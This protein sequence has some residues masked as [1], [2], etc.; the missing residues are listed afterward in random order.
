MTT[1][2]TITPTARAHR[3]GALPQVADRWNH[4]LANNHL[5][6][7]EFAVGRDI[8]CGAAKMIRAH[9][10]T[11]S[12]SSDA[13][14]NMLTG[15][16]AEPN[17]TPIQIPD[18]TPEAFTN[19]LSYIYTGSVKDLNEDNVQPT[20]YCADKYELPW[21]ADLCTEFVLDLLKPE[22]C[23]MHLE[24]ALHWTK[25]CDVVIE[26]CWDIVD[27]SSEAVLQSDYFSEMEWT[28]LDMLLQRNT[29]SAEENTVYLAAEKWARAACAR[30]NLPADAAHRRRILGSALYRVRF[31]LMTD[32]QLATGPFKDK[33]K[34]LTKT[35]LDTL[36]Q[37]K[38]AASNNLQKF[39]KEPRKYVLCNIGTQYLYKLDEK[40]F[41]YGLFETGYWMPAT[42]VGDSVVYARGKGRVAFSKPDKTVRAVDTLKHGLPVEAYI[43]GGYK[44]ATYGALRAGLHIVNVAGRECRVEFWELKIAGQRLEEWKAMRM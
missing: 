17:G 30:K 18:I 28:T 14:N 7:V 12:I 25:D 10:L 41:V 23:L 22:N 16:S 11:L 27:A 5:T 43:D 36:Y 44:E 2:P 32:E 34:L 8:E 29:L 24:N 40:I 3:R 21:L 37:I 26:K 31:P 4:A 19:M 1:T 33:D 20:L 39:S 35:E 38:H 9:R 42:T 6:D 15:N 13:F